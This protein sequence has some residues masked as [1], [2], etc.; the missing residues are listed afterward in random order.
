MPC[1]LAGRVLNRQ[2]NMSRVRSLTIDGHPHALEETMND[3][4]G[5]GRG[6]P[7]FVVCESVE[8]L[9]DRLDIFLSENFLDK[10]D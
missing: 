10:F 2:R 4:K 9:Q 8:S 6:G 1:H 5:L 3:S 7:S